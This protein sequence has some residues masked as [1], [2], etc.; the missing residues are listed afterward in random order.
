M[1]FL[2]V[3][4]LV[5]VAFVKTF[6]TKALLYLLSLNIRDAIQV[7]ARQGSTTELSSQVVP[8]K[9]NLFN[10]SWIFCC[11]G[12]VLTKALLDSLGKEILLLPQ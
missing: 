11:V 1:G 2:A 5:V 3:F 7:L 12:L 8:K 10:G 4:S 6:P 9:T